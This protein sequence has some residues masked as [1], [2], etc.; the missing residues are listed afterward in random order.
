MKL[1]FTAVFAVLLSLMFSS[2]LKAEE[3]KPACELVAAL[4]AANCIGLGSYMSDE[5][6]WCGSG[7]PTRALNAEVV[8]IQSQQ[9]GSNNYL[10][11]FD[12]GQVMV[13]IV[14]KLWSPG[15]QRIVCDVKKLN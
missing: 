3:Q 2:L 6:V 12:D 10:V 11:S 8:D 14:E 7:D 9:D 5:V 15:S 1:S 13:N 4:A